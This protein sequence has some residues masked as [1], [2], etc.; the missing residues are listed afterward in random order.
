MKKLKCEDI[1][2]WRSSI[3]I[4]EHNVS[5]ECEISSEW[6]APFC[7]KDMNTSIFFVYLTLNSA[8]I[9]DPHYIFVHITIGE[10]NE[11]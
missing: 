11:I 2:I 9:N 8:M 1:K 10:N 7:E 6:N 3:Y 5:S 4:E